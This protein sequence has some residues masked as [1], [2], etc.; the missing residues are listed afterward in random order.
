MAERD[1][2]SYLEGIGI[3]VDGD[4]DEPQPRSDD[5]RSDRDDLIAEE[6]GFA[7]AGADEGDV[8]EDAS[9]ESEAASGAEGARGVREGDRPAGSGVAQDRW[10]HD[11]EEIDFERALA[12][13]GLGG[14]VPDDLSPD[15]RAETFLVQL[16]LY[17]D[18]T[19]AVD[20]AVEH[21]GTVHMDVHGGDAGR[22]IG[23][24]GRTLAALEFL[25]N[26]VV[27]KVEGEPPVRVNVDIGGY[28]R[29]RD[30]RLRQVAQR[31]AARVRKTS[32]AVELEPMSAA[33]RRVV[34]VE[35]ADD[36]TV[37]SESAGEGRDRRVV[38]YP[39]ADAD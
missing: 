23:K 12:G 17:L 8:A 20:V 16:L 38:I 27:N 39:A 31:A 26:A 6:G 19:Y 2:D 32:M 15:Q 18:P 13:A 3:D 14:V 36:P 1:L 34:H 37:T 10:S 9:P 30:E 4:R 33:E 11:D 29:R 22:L 7:D 5:D 28:K 35:L 25:T 24:G 21:D